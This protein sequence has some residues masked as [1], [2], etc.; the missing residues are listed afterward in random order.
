MPTA[1]TPRASG[2]STEDS[3]PEEAAAAA[4]SACAAATAS[5]GDSDP[6]S[7][8]TALGSATGSVSPGSTR[9]PTPLPVGAAKPQSSNRSAC[10]VVETG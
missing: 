10:S 5:S 7:G 1:P 9:V 2:T 3:P 6:S 8:A 4:G